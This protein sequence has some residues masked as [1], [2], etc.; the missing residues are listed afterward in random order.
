MVFAACP[1]IRVHYPP[2]ICL[3]RM[4]C[5]CG[6]QSKSSSS[7][8]RRRNVEAP[9]RTRRRRSS[10]EPSTVVSV[11][12]A[13]DGVVE[14]KER[15]RPRQQQ[16]K[17][18]HTGDFPVSIPAPEKRR[19]RSLSLEVNQQGWPSWLMAVAGEAIRDWSPRRANTFEKLEKVA[20]FFST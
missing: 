4:G 13:V 7:D 19:T 11:T 18:R 5:V 12:D 17:A 14:V 9:P 1:L 2:C 3:E 8:H 10:D 6:K 20:T 15:E 16:Q